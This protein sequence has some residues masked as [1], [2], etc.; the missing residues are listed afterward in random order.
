MRDFQVVVTGIQGSCQ[1]LP[2][3][4]AGRQ[5]TGGSKDTYLGSLNIIGD[6]ELIAR[7][8]EVFALLWSVLARGGQLLQQLAQSRVFE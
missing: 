5:S 7:H 1:Q 6:I 3:S 4:R 2:P 8:R